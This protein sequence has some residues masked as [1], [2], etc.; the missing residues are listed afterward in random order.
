M[1]HDQGQ[2]L[3]EETAANTAALNRI[4]DRLDAFYEQM[5]AEKAPKPKHEKD[6]K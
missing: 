4:A 6:A 3:L 2:R 5:V 1:D